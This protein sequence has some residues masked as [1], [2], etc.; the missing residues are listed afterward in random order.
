[1]RYIRFFNELQL[2]DIPLVG[3]KNASLGEMYQKLTPKGILVPN[4]FATTSEAYYL[5]LEE[6]GIKAMIEKHLRHVDVS[7]TDVLQASGKAIRDCILE[8]TL[9][10]SLT[11]ELLSAYAMLSREYGVEH[12]DVA[13]RSSGTAEDLPDASFAG[14]QETFLNI[15]SPEKLL[16]SVKQCYASL[17]TDRAISYR[18]SRGF[19]HF[20][21]ALSVGVQK[22]VRSDKA[23]SGVMFSIDTESGSHDLV[24]INA[25]W[26]LGENVVSGRVNADEFFV[27]K[28]T[29]AK[30]FPTIL[31]HSLGSKKERMLYHHLHQTINVPTSN[32]EQ[33]NFSINDDEVLALAHQALLIEA[34]YERP[35]DIEWAKD[36]ND[37]KLYIVQA[38][39]ETVQSKR[40]I[41]SIEKY[42]LSSKNA[43]ILATG[44]AVGDK[45]GSGAVKIIH[46]TSEFASFN[47]GDILVADTTNPDWEPIMKKASAVV[48]NRG[49]RT[50]HAA[51]VAREIG[52]PAVV[53]CGNGTD[54]LANVPE[55]T[56]SCAE[57][58]EGYIYKG[59]LPFTCKTIDMNLHPTKTK[60]MMN[61]GNPAEAFNLAKMPNDGVGLARME[62]IMTHSINAHPMAL[63]DLYQGKGIEEEENIR[64][65][66][67][68]YVDAK[69][70]FIDKLCEG[71]GLIAAAFYPRAVIIR[72]SDFKS[73]EYA[74]MPGGKV[75]EV[76]EENPMIGFR[77]A[78]RYY[79]ESY[80]E[81]FAWECEA[82]KKV[83][84]EMGL[85]NVIIMLPFVRTPEEGKKVIE[86]MNAQGLV[87]GQN[88]LKIYAMCEIPAN[89][90]I[91]DAFLDIFDGYSIGSNDL[92]QLV[93][94]VD[95]D[96]GKIAHVFNER[97]P[98]VKAM[99]KMA[100]EAC[101]RRGKYI[102]I[103]GQAPS[104]YP[105][106]T[107]FLVREG[108]ESISLNPDSL[109][110]MHHVVEEIEAKVL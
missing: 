61:V 81:A 26:G 28:P 88:S 45:I 52:V 41:Q 29:L 67:K 66:M 72:T 80:K 54:V 11:Q 48:T 36:G 39:P 23:S 69:A 99:L 76:D 40:D 18:S 90:I 49:S 87:Q 20:K 59:K 12:V 97:N 55:V 25:T 100:I 32:E 109:Y 84:D 42:T 105:E 16:Q 101:K 60:L 110:K 35:M 34:Y 56:V 24:L 21:V 50:C 98:A 91:A 75:Y 47:A 85:D 63:V 70:F 17:F 68:P 9:P 89:V 102:G 64:S 1:M 58:E 30:G 103:C 6:N 108:I 13:V 8:A 44:R 38:R 51:I 4:G 79:D 10:L 104:D 37:G 31:K 46:D 65:F 14:Q 74:N 107:E 43:T 96:S 71:I 2:S 93:L 22:M 73:N 62:F 7:N 86:I 33:N 94:G 77:G 5:L 57:G 19:D 78:S 95:R 92:T 83:R 82:L 15:D 3:G 27:F 53:G 106:I